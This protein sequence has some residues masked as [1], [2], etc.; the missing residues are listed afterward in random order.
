MSSII[1]IWAAKYLYLSFF[2]IFCILKYSK[3]YNKQM[4]IFY[5]ILELKSSFYLYM[6]TLIPL[7]VYN[8]LYILYLYPCIYAD[9]YILSF[10]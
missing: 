9:T 6:Y 2:M 1:H 4:L 10:K 8:T 5:S 3:V 7:Y